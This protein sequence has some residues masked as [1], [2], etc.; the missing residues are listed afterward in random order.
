MRKCPLPCQRRRVGVI[1]G[2]RVIVKPVR[3]TIIEM[4]FKRLA[5]GGQRGF[6]IRPARIDPLVQFPVMQQQRRLNAGHVCGCGLT[7]IKRHRSRHFRIGHRQRI[8]HAPAIAETNRANFARRSFMAHKVLKSCK[9]ILHQLG[10]IHRPLHRPAVIIIARITSQRRQTVGTKGQVSGLGR[11]AHNVLDIGVQPTVFVDHQHRWQLACR[12]RRLC[13][14]PLN[15][16]MPIRA[17]IGDA[18]RLDGRI[19]RGHLF[20]Q[21]I[22]GLQALQNGRRR[23]AC[24]YVTCCI[25]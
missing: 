13:H 11:A 6:I 9:K 1:T 20:G 14:Q 2:R 18:D 3:R 17:L 15:C 8:A 12:P 25:P 21:R 19:V 23:D 16:A 5:I 10:A 24:G 7:A 4:R 22:I